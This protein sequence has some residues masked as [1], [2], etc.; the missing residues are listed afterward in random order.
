MYVVAPLKDSFVTSPSSEATKRRNEQAA[1]MV[2]GNILIL[3]LFSF[4][5][6]LIAAAFQRFRRLSMLDAYA[7]VAFPSLSYIVADLTFAGIVMGSF[8]LLTSDRNDYG[9]VPSDD[10]EVSREPTAMSSNVINGPLG[11]VMGVLGLIALLVIYCG[12]VHSLLKQMNPR[13]HVYTQFLSRSLFRRM[14][15]P[16]TF[17]RP[18][19]QRL[20]FGRHISPFSSKKNALIGTYSLP[21]I[22][23]SGAILYLFPMTVECDIRLWVLVG[24]LLIVAVVL[25]VTRPYRYTIETVLIISGLLLLSMVAGTMALQVR[26]NNA[27][28][29]DAQTYLVVALILLI[30]IRLVFTVTV[31]FLEYRVWRHFQEQILNDID[32][33]IIDGNR[34]ATLKQE[35]LDEDGVIRVDRGDDYFAN[36]VKKSK[37]KI[38]KKKSGDKEGSFTLRKSDTIVANSS[39]ALLMEPMAGEAPTMLMEGMGITHHGDEAADDEQEF[40]EREAK[41]MPKRPATRLSLDDSSE[42]SSSVLSD[43]DEG[44]EMQNPETVNNGSFSVPIDSADESPS[45]DAFA[46]SDASESEMEDGSEGSR[47]GA[48]DE[49]NSSSHRT[50]QSTSDSAIDSTDTSSTE[51]TSSEEDTS[52]ED[53]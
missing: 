5:Q 1:G 52:D 15:F 41:T 20:A 40:S 33:D 43:E 26:N 3:F 18:E 38:P 32:E 8:M 24:L 50:L 14:F 39:M 51:I 36:T 13:F 45:S 21:T 44:S 10:D 23:L 34:A 2:F 4:V 53:F 12:V 35:E 42:E 29:I 49:K 46:E 25:A 27:S 22:F 19:V 9:T 17:I 47:S 28:L 31:V 7:A 30:I 37:V 11:I 48:R 6:R 16:Q